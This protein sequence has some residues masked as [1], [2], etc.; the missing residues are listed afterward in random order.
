MIRRSPSGH[1]CGESHHKTKLSD[2]QVKSMRNTYAK[3]QDEEK[4]MGYES[5][6]KLYGC[7]VSTAR[8]IVTYR[9]RI[10]A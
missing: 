9:T 2:A 3:W 8:D 5:L 7:G 1:R 4:R 6:A 10:N